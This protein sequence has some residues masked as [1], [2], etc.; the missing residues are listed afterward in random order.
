MAD[1]SIDEVIKTIDKLIAYQGI[2]EDYLYGS[3][4]RGSYCLY[5]VYSVWYDLN[6]QGLA[7]ELTIQMKCLLICKKRLGVVYPKMPREVSMIITL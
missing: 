1:T 4:L 5:F 7:E 6:N 2:D 3:Y